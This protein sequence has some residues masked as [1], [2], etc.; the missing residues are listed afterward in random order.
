M[1]QWRGWFALVTSRNGFTSRFTLVNASSRH[2]SEC[3]HLWTRHTQCAVLIFTSI[4]LV[5]LYSCSGGGSFS[6]CWLWLGMVRCCEVNCCE[7]GKGGAPTCEN[8]CPGGFVC[9]GPKK[10]HSFQMPDC[11][12]SPVKVSKSRTAGWPKIWSLY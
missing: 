3:Q 6:F 10:S 7:W 8:V 1:M 11:F 4:S 2:V 9:N 12:L 5:L